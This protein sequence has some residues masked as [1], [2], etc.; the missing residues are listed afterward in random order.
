MDAGI[1]VAYLAAL[2]VSVAA[3]V[4]VFVFC[5]QAAK[6]KAEINIAGTFFIYTRIKVYKNY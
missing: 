1:S 2:P 4:S 3:A 5:V 6:R